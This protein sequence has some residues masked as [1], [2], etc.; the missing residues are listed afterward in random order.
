MIHFYLY[1]DK[2]KET[3]ISI[4]IGLL[5]IK[6]IILYSSKEYN[7]NNGVPK[8]LLNIKENSELSFYITATGYQKVITIITVNNDVSPIN[9]IV[10]CSYKN[11]NSNCFDTL[12]Q[13]L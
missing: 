13:I 5:L 8:S 2:S 9:Q 10:T 1:I 4:I 11:L 12:K 6:M 7:L 3:M